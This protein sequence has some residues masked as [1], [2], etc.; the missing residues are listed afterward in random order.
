MTESKSPVPNLA[1]LRAFQES[2]PKLV[3]LIG[4]AVH[5]GFTPREILEKAIDYSHNPLML[6]L[7]LVTARQQVSFMQDCIPPKSLA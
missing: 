6:G 1:T 7:I 3:A 4:R 2:N 5:G